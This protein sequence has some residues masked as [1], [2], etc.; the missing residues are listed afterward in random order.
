ML[1]LDSKL[2]PTLSVEAAAE[3][4][5]ISRPTA[6]QAVK[7][8]DIPAIKVGRRLLVPTALLL[9][10]LGVEEEQVVA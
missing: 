7:T 4:L 6:Y 1:A 9:K 5:G 10:M 2:P 3:I 8:G